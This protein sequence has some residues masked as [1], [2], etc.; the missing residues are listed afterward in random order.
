MEPIATTLS[1]ALLESLSE[2]VCV[3]VCVQKLKGRKNGQAAS[4]IE[5]M[6]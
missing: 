1:A 2:E 4:S 5:I 6:I 3:C